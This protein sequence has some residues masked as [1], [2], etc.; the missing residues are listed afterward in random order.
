MFLNDQP[1]GE[2]GII[3]PIVLK[4]FDIIYPVTALELSIELFCRDQ[5]QQKLPT[6]FVM[7]AGADVRT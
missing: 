7:P 1:C 3:H 6:H 4:A 5:M 2:F